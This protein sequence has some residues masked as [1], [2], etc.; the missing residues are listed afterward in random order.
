[1]RAAA[2]VAATS[3]EDCPADTTS[4]NKL[5]LSAE[6]S[7]W[8][9]SRPHGQPAKGGVV[10]C[11]R[12]PGRGRRGARR[13]QRPTCGGSRAPSRRAARAHCS[14]RASCA[15]RAAAPARQWRLV[16]LWC[17][18]PRPQ[19]AVIRQPWAS[20]VRRPDPG[21][22]TVA[23]A[24]CAA[25]ASAATASVPAAAL[26]VAGSSAATAAAGA[27][28]ATAALAP[29]RSSSAAGPGIVAMPLAVLREGR[30]RRECGGGAGRGRQSRRPGGGLVRLTQ[31]SPQI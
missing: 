14:P 29:A 15:P 9:R 2:V 3:W 16:W 8:W 5:S 22:R 4:C 23:S 20:E 6:R 7:A 28:V 18:G 11:W 10:T 13:Q 27:A 12:H 25:K 19:A 26:P 21:C 31:H 24:A 1:M 30:R 17:A